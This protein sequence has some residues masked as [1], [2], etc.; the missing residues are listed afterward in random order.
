MIECL[1]LGGGF[2]LMLAVGSPIIINF[3]DM[4]RK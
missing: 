2:L 4:E 1:A 3:G